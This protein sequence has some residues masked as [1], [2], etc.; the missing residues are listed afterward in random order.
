MQQ[1]V[2]AALA[3][4]FRGVS[5]SIDCALMSFKAHAILFVLPALYLLGN[6]LL[7]S[8]IDHRRGASWSDVFLAAFQVGMPS[9]LF[10]LLLIRLF[11]YLFII[12]PVSPLRALLGDTL[13]LFRSPWPFLNALPVVFVMV[14][15]NK[16]MLDLKPAIP[17]INPFSWDLALAEI[18]RALHL[19][20]DPWRLLQPLLGHAMIT[21][22]INFAYCF[23]FL[24]LFTS[25][26]WFAFQRDYTQLRIRF[27]L[28]TTMVWWIGG[29]LMAVYF[30]SAGP[31]YY[32]LIGLSPDPFAPLMAYLR[33]VDSFLP[34]W[35]L[36]AQSLLWNTYTA[37]DARFLG[38]SAFPSMH[39]AVAVVIALAGFR[40]HRGLGW[41][42]SAYALLILLGSIHLGW[43]YAVD[44]YAAIGLALL[45][46]W[47]SGSLARL[48]ERL[49]WVK[50]YRSIV[51]G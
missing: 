43:H 5:R 28:A 24:A 16:A 19:G 15:L 51:A 32:S 11:Q 17:D 47:I 27:F 35:A 44:S 42:L 38:I 18:D 29:G 3:V 33:D 50:S 49:P 6:E 1:G 21:A 41:A 23:W 45:A 8:G 4:G 9:A 10:T 12:K 13:A 25:D 46:W 2:S 26:Y 40:I 37:P 7:L 20:L 30:S 14:M 34:M 31:A 39:N 48:N 36:D 22:V